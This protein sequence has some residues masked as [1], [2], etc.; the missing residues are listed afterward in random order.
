MLKAYYQDLFAALRIN[1][2]G[3][4]SW[5][6]FLY[7]IAVFTCGLRIRISKHDFALIVH[8]FTHSLQVN[9]PS[10]K[11]ESHMHVKRVQTH[12]HKVMPVNKRRHHAID[13]T[14]ISTHM[15]PQQN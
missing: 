14:Q 4:F 12:A 10:L 15:H 9:Q 2:A 3:L 13:V 8:V 5:T 7:P 1:K 11:N 6:Q